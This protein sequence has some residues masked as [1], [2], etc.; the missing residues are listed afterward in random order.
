MEGAADCSKRDVRHELYS[1][2]SFPGLAASLEW[3]PSPPSA[4]PSLLLPLI[5]FSLP[6][7]EHTAHQQRCWPESPQAPALLARCPPPQLPLPAV[8]SFAPLGTYGW[9]R[10]HSARTLLSCGV[11]CCG[12]L[13]STESPPIS[14]QERSL[15]RTVSD[16]HHRHRLHRYHFPSW[17]RARKL[18]QTSCKQSSSLN[19]GEPRTSSSTSVYKNVTRFL[20]LKPSHCTWKT[21]TPF[22]RKAHRE[23][24]GWFS[25]CLGFF[26][27]DSSSSKKANHKRSISVGCHLC[28]TEGRNN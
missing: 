20:M 3:L 2:K 12:G 22:R 14:Q 28:L 24:S 16:N 13:V 18:L 6:T 5:P 1:V 10:S 26:W 25:V 4:P 17:P 19:Y 8:K 15:P 23:A 9:R 11:S 27:W 21:V 7:G